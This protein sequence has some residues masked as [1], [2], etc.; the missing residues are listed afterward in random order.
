MK[1]I[2]AFFLM[3]LII[4]TAGHTRADQLCDIIA[5]LQP[6]SIDIHAGVAPLS[7]HGRKCFTLADVTLARP[8]PLGNLASFNDLYR[9]PWD[10]GFRLGWDWSDAIEI[11]FDFDYRQASPRCGSDRCNAPGSTTCCGIFSLCFSTPNGA[12]T[13]FLVGNLAKYR[14]YAAYAGA[15]WYCPYLYIDCCA[16]SFA[17]FVGA[18]IGLVNHQK[19][20]ILIN[21]VT[22]L[23]NGSVHIAGAPFPQTNVPLFLSNTTISA[24]GLIGI[25]WCFYDGFSLIFQTEFLVQGA[26]KANKSLL[27]SPRNFISEN[28]QFA[29]PTTITCPNLGI[30]PVNPTI[31]G[32]GFKYELIFPITFGLEYNF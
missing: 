9:L 20:T 16:G 14:T 23:I 26:L 18:K 4:G 19:I 17:G 28:V 10:I 24:G 13:H 2:S 31:I 5:C 15:R 29:C 21:H 12:V 22:Q 1:K 6:C 11:L 3:A 32:A 25:D 30:F 27:G 8:V 7:W